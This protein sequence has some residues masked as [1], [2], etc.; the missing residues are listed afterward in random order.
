MIAIFGSVIAANLIINIIGAEVG[1]ILVAI[2]TITRMSISFLMTTSLACTASMNAIVS[3]YTLIRDGESETALA[4]V[5][6][7]PMISKCTSF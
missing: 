3:T 7:D 1:A 2:G 5:F 4:A 6:A